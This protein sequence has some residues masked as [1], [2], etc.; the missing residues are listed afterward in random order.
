MC[1]MGLTVKRAEGRT[2]RLHV[3]ARLIRLEAFGQHRQSDETMDS[4]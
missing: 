1:T 2:S 3:W 4:S